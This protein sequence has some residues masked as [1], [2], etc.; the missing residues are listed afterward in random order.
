LAWKEVPRRHRQVPLPRGRSI[1]PSA[2]ARRGRNGAA[3]A[4]GSEGG[5][6]RGEHPRLAGHLVQREVPEAS[7]CRVGET[8]ATSPRRP[9]GPA[10]GAGS[11]RVPGR[12]EGSIFTST[13]SLSASRRCRKR[14][15]VGVGERGASSRRRTPRPPAGGAGSEGLPRRGDASTLTSPVY[16]SSRRCRKR[17]PPAPRRRVRGRS[18]GRR[19]GR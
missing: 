2:G 8:R 11:K 10:R 16:W 19:G 3:G 15:R 4:A 13:D 1:F 7:A 12:G 17:G 9:P 6:R 14:G 18:R 5:P